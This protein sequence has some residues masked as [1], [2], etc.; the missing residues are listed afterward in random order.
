MRRALRGLLGV[1]V[2]AQAVPAWAGILEGNHPKVAQGT[3]AYHRGDYEGALR[4]YEEAREE[5]PRKA[6]LDFNL[7]DVYMKLGRPDDARR[8]FEAALSEAGDDLKVRDYYNLG[9]ALASLNREADAMDAYRQALKVDPSFEPAR[10][11]LEV[12]L[13]K[14]TQPQQKPVQGD[15]GLPDA[16][17]DAGGNDGG[18]GKDGGSSD[19]GGSDGGADGGTDGGGDG[20]AG[21]VGRQGDAGG[22]SPDA[23]SGQDGGTMANDEQQPPEPPKPVDRQEAERLLEAVRRNEKQFLM[24]QHKQ[25]VK[26][27]AHPEKDW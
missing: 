17:P 7:G 4:F 5:L 13:R 16:G 23:S 21:D 20:G 25:K 2:A 15:G 1:L 26:Q 12:L 11:N 19:S 27:R 22:E 24:Q 3:E 10:H 9:N 18:D 6:V 14:K 8:A